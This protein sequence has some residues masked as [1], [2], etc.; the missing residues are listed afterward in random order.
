MRWFSGR[1]AHGIEPNP[2]PICAAL[3][4]DGE[5]RLT[6]FETHARPVPPGNGQATDNWS[7]A[8]SAAAVHSRGSSDIWRPP[9]WITTWMRTD[10]RR[11]SISW[12]RTP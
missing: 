1:Q 6:H 8:A 7:G 12:L 11:A 9:P 10:S 2:C 4:T 5:T 3:V